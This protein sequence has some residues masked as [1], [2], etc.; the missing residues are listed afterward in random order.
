MNIFERAARSKLRYPSV[1]GELTTEDLWDLPL[2]ASARA[3]R[4]VKVDLDTIARS[5][6][7]TLR[8]MDQDSF[9][10]LKPDPR[11]GILELQL[12][13]LKHIIASKVADQQAAQTRADKAEQRR[14]L[15]EALAQ[16]E[17]AEVG[18]MSKEEILSKLAEL[19]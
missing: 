16:K 9:V 6:S 5:V 7:V 3:T 13:I 8:G 19:N 14:I 15:T 4:D 12:E 11:K 10:E 17:T 2:I 18:A 1:K